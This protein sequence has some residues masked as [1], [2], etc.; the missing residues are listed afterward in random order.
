MIFLFFCIILD[1]F[2]YIC[3]MLSVT[4][5]FT[6]ICICIGTFKWEENG[7]ELKSVEGKCG[8]GRE[9]E[10]GKWKRITKSLHLLL[11]VAFFDSSNVK[12]YFGFKLLTNVRK[13]QRNRVFWRYIHKGSLSRLMIQ[14]GLV[15]IPQHHLAC[16][17]P[18]RFLNWSLMDKGQ[19]VFCVY[20]K[21]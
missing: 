21:L 7:I 1:N 13:H 5:T 19:G 17:C 12:V 10:G 6:C 20:S 4:S 9:G 15:N 3:I 8:G 14:P 18:T 2:W 16:S 11:N